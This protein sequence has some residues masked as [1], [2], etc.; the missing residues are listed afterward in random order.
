MTIF[1]KIRVL[2]LAKFLIGD[3]SALN[4]LM[5]KDLKKLQ[6]GHPNSRWPQETSATRSEYEPHVKFQV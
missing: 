3:Q 5:Y 4:W 6:D 2:T 1:N